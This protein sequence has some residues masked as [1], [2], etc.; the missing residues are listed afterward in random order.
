VGICF[1]VLPPLFQAAQRCFAAGPVIYNLCLLDIILYNGA[2][3]NMASEKYLKNMSSKYG[4]DLT[5]DFY[6]QFPEIS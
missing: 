2:Y 3:V 1:H 4:N 5:A 6:Y